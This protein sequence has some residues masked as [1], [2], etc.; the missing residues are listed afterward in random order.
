MAVLSVIKPYAATASPPGA[1]CIAI[2]AGATPNSGGDSF[3]NDGRSIIRL[4]NTGGSDRTVSVAPFTASPANYVTYKT[5]AFTS[6]AT[7]GDI[8]TRTFEPAIY[9]N[10][11]GEVPLTYDGAITGTIWIISASGI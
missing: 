10:A 8:V 9:N 2:G 5:W 11:S 4:K 1:G 6:V 3:A 7:T